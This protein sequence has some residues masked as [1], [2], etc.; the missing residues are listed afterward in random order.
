MKQATLVNDGK[1]IITD[2]I[3]CKLINT[4]RHI[5]TE[6]Y[7]LKKQTIIVNGLYLKIG[8][9]I[10]KLLN[11]LLTGIW[12]MTRIFSMNTPTIKD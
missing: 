12:L 4:T 8:G 5:E 6:R 7:C 3:I 1:T 9:S 2:L 10:I 11:F